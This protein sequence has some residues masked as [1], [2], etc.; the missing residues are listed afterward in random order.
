MEGGLT[1]EGDYSADGHYLAVKWTDIDPD[2]T[3][4]MVGLAPVTGGMSP[5]EQID[6]PDNNIVLRISSKSTQFLTV[7]QSNKKHTLTQSF[8]LNNLILNP[9]ADTQ[10]VYEVGDKYDALSASDERLAE[11][12]SSDNAL[13]RPVIKEIKRNKRKK[14]ND[15]ISDVSET[16]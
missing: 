14:V 6:N 15:N 12:A 8:R 4:L 16:E 5:S 9:K 13:G 11:L 3:S 2:A 7:T 1:D 10:D